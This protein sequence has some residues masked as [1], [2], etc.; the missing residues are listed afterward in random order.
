MGNIKKNGNLEDV[1]SL[2]SVTII[3][4]SHFLT[5]LFH[6]V[7]VSSSDLGL[8]FGLWKAFVVF[9]YLW[10]SLYTRLL[11]LCCFFFGFGLSVF[12]ILKCCSFRTFDQYCLGFGHLTVE[13]NCELGYGISLRFGMNK[14]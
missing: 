14:S 4:T 7:N 12:Y 1:A 8:G 10:I 13:S 3:T 11:L 6:V 5:S 9:F 2:L